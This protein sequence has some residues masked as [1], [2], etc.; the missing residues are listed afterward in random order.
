MLF[1]SLWLFEPDLNNSNHNWG[2]VMLQCVATGRPAYHTQTNTVF[3]PTD[4]LV[5][6]ISDL[7]TWTV[8]NFLQLNQYKAEVHIVG[9]KA[10]RENLATHFNSRAIK[11]KHLVKNLGV[12]LDSEL[13]FESHIRNVTKIAFY[14]LKNIAT[15]Q[16][17]LS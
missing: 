16:P 3:S 9:A 11:I 14:H 5:D 17:F 13:N 7:N 15:V 6:C 1:I 2:S 10:Q 12:I 4:I 8:H